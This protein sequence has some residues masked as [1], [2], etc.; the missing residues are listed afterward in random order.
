MFVRKDCV[1]EELH[2]KGHPWFLKE[3]EI[4]SIENLY[5]NDRKPISTGITRHEILSTSGWNH[6]NDVIMNHFIQRQCK[7]VNGA[8]STTSYLIPAIAK[9]H[10]NYEYQTIVAECDFADTN[11]IVITYNRE[12]NVEH[13]SIFA[14]YPKKYS[15]FYLD[16]KKTVCAFNCVLH[17]LKKCFQ[18][19]QIK[20]RLNQWFLIALQ[21]IPYQT[22]SNSCGPLACL[23]AYNIIQKT[24]YVCLDEELTYLRYWIASAIDI[25]EETVEM[26]KNQKK[27]IPQKTDVPKKKKL[28]ICRDVP[29][30]VCMEG[31]KSIFDQINNYEKPPHDPFIFSESESSD[32]EERVSDR[33]RNENTDSEDNMELEIKDL[34]IKAFI[35]DKNFEKML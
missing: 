14:I 28:E 11:L 15:I 23:N 20:F 27:F 7:N 1:R 5:F 19:K 29:G 9:S 18:N 33:A 17:L 22:D 12:G 25:S 13:W 6:F 10:F 2:N 24:S 16:S 30:Y 8:I 26:E 21:D 31:F 35:N 34:E 32:G 4:T 3:A